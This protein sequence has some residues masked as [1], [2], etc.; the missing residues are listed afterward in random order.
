MTIFGALWFLIK[1]AFWSGVA[2]LAFAVMFNVPV[3]TLGAC[4][5]G[6][7]VGYLIRTI[8]MEGGIGIEGATLAG[9]TVVGFMGEMFARRWS[10]PASV[11]TVP[12]VIPMLPGTFAYNT[13]IGV[14]RIAPHGEATPISL[15]ISTAVNGSKTVLILSAIAIG[16][17]APA[18]LI[19]QRRL[20]PGQRS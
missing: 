15:I 3:R 2:S 16:I 9:A 7:A 5:L 13:M 4:A 8:L 6:G 10:A 19:Y 11:F 14:L 20:P 18:L 1:D 17:A 12:A